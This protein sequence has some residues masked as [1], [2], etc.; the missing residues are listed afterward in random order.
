MSL[1]SGSH[2]APWHGALLL[3]VIAVAATGSTVVATHHAPGVQVHVLGEKIQASSTSITTGSSGN[4]GSGLGNGGGTKL[5]FTMTASVS[6]LVLGRPTV[7]P[8]VITNPS[9]N[10][11]TLTV[12]SMSAVAE[13][14]VSNGSVTCAGSNLV[15][16]SYDS[17]QPGATSYAIPSGKSATVNLP[18]VFQDLTTV[19]Q[20]P[21]K[22]KTFTLDL[23]GAA[24]VTR[25]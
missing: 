5:A 10:N 7:L 13:D 11:G 17:T 24:T 25:P 16:T 23:N 20:T 22:G 6:G 14:L 15:V 8:V 4:N 1:R 3:S 12:N 2:L 18:I 19:D 9:S 21:C